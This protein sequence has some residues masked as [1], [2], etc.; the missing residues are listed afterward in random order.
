MGTILKK[1]SVD[2]V[3]SKKLDQIKADP[4][5]SLLIIG[6]RGVGTFDA[7]RYLAGNSLVDIIQPIDAKDIADS[8][9]G[10]IRVKQIRSLIASAT[11]KSTTMRV[12][13]ID[14]AEKMNH[15]AQNAFL[16]LLEEPSSMTRFILVSTTTSALLPTVLSRTQKLIMPK[17]SDKAIVRLLN[18]QGIKDDKILAQIVYLSEGQP[19]YASELAHDHDGI[20]QKGAV[21]RDAQLLLRGTLYQKLVL[22]GTYSSDRQKSL[23]LLDAARIILTKSLSSSPSP[24]T[25]TVLARLSDAYD[26]IS[27]NGNARLQMMAF[28]V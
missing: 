2:F 25:V 1:P 14:G 20:A 26:R 11:T 28:V 4:P 6:A 27:T 15:A 23:L 13:I 21:L 17:A 9:K 3:T 16:K 18:K 24:Q 19:V 5:Q 8:E 12:Y 22:I 10:T 7:A